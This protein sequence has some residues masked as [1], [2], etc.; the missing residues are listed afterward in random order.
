MKIYRDWG[1][2]EFSLNQ[3]LIAFIPE[4]VFFL[5][6]LPIALFWLSDKIDRVLS[7]PRFGGGIW[8]IAAGILLMA[9]GFFLGMWA[10]TTQVTS[11]RGTPVPMMPTQKVVAQGPYAYSRNPMTLGTMLAYWGIGFII[12]SFSALALVLL[13]GSVLLMYCRFI[14]EKELAARFGEEYLEYKRTTPFLIPRFS[15]KK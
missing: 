11:G 7:I 1:K 14:E 10:I 2:R 3:R 12:G 8:N 9:G 5:L 6:F 13:A 4:G 15:R